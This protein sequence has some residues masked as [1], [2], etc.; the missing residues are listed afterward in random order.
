MS[1]YLAA[2]MLLGFIAYSGFIYHEGKTSESH[3]CGEAD[4]LHD[5]TQDQNTIAAHKHVE[6]IIQK[7]GTITQGV[8]NA[9]ETK[10]NTIDAEYS[11][12]IGVQSLTTPN[13]TFNNLSSSS[14]STH[15]VNAGSCLTAKSK[16]FKLTPKQC[17]ERMEK[18]IDLRKWINQQRA[19][20][21]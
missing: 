7:Q 19:I 12:A 20:V 2:G 10:R 5:V 17:D 9:Y 13:S 21:K 18:L 14:D 4:A 15:G 16:V 11:N 6:D 1:P 3:I 8:T